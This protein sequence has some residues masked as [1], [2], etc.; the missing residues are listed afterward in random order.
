MTL[1]AVEEVQEE[2]IKR[3]KVGEALK[4]DF[5]SL[6]SKKKHL[7]DTQYQACEIE[8]SFQDHLK[9]LRE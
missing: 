5:D 4:G 6:F 1:K 7:A 8:I 3:M 9:K 2:Q